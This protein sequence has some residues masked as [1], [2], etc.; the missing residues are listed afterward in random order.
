MSNGNTKIKEEEVW[1]QRGV[2]LGRLLRKNY[3]LRPIGWLIFAPFRFRDRWITK[4]FFDSYTDPKIFLY[5][6][7][8]EQHQFEWFFGP[9]GLLSE[10][11]N[12]CI[13]RDW[14][15]DY[16]PPEDKERWKEYEASFEGTLQRWWRITNLRH[17]LPFIMIFGPQNNVSWYRL[18]LTYRSRRRDKGQAIKDIVREIKGRCKQCRH[19]INNRRLTNG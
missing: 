10:F 7:Y 16:R 1:Y 4:K 6:L 13:L 12:Y 14:R 2:L 18:S 15:R 9:A 11:G 3:I 5:F 8:S 17:D 19:E